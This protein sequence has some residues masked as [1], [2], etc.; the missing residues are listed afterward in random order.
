MKKTFLMLLVFLL[1]ALVCRGQKYI[2]LT[3]DDGPSVTTSA[4]LDVL[5][6]NG[7]PA[8][9]FV[10]GY[11]INRETAEIM[12][13]AVS[14]GCDVE[15]HTTTH[16]H[17]PALTVEEMRA[18]M[19]VTDA[20]IETYLGKAPDYFR[21]PYIDTCPLMHEVID[22]TFIAGYSCHD[23]QSGMTAEEK[24]ELV[25]S[26]AKDGLIVLLHDFKGNLTTVEALKTI[27][28]ALKEQ[29]YTFVTVPQLFELQGVS[30]EPHCGKVFSVVAR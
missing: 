10:I 3:F 5:E 25:L 14:L 23:W 13:R 8:S 21:P 28:P 22:K 29:G 19:A 7:I 2:A 18:E 4:V 26:H 30:H 11:N 20:L 27:I 12:R 15:S 6:A 1:P 9:F 16:P 24:V 17:M